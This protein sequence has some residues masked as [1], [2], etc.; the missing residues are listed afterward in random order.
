[1]AVGFITHL[2]SLQ[3][4]LTFPE[5]VF[6]QLD[7]LPVQGIEPGSLGMHLP[8]LQMQVSIGGA[9]VGIGFAHPTAQSLHDTEDVLSSTH[10]VLLSQMQ[11]VVS[12]GSKFGFSPAGG[13]AHL[14]AFC[15]CKDRCTI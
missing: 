10:P 2:L 5:Q 1:M 11:V 9:G 8:L 6:T 13:L 15:A 12:G 14:R 4:Q 7:E 3:K